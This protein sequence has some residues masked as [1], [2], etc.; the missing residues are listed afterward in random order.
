[1]FDVSS[2]EKIRQ[3]REKDWSRQ[4]EHMQVLNGTGQGVQR[5]NQE[6]S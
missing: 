1:M 2:L 4:V 6:Q 5:I 3:V